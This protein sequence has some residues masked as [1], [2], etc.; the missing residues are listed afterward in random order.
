MADP[1][2]VVP[3]LTREYF[4]TAFD[5]YKRNIESVYSDGYRAGYTAGD[6][7]AIARILKAA[8]SD[9]NGQAQ[10]A[11]A[12]ATIP[13]RTARTPQTSQDKAPGAATHKL[14]EAV[15]RATPTGKATPTEIAASPANKTDIAR[16]AIRNAMRRGKKSGRYVSDGKGRYSLGK[17]EVQK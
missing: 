13:P 2:I 4:A 6:A 9:A 11:T 1:E 16:D 7:A 17:T 10:T 12:A 3:K 15:L 14:I 8:Q 5:D